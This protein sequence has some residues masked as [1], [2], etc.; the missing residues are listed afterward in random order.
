MSARSRGL[1]RCPAPRRVDARSIYSFAPFPTCRRCVKALTIRS[2]EPPQLPRTE[3]HV[4]DLLAESPR[5]VRA[6]VSLTGVN[7]I[8]T[9]DLGP[10]CRGSQQLAHSN[11]RTPTPTV[12][13]RVAP[14]AFL[15]G[16]LLVRRFSQ[17]RPR[18]P[19]KSLTNEALQMSLRAGL[20]FQ[21]E[22]TIFRELFGRGYSK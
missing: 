17:R 8:L 2:Y 19:K 16:A 12:T 22:R 5:H 10:L 7:A 9:Y 20:L 6:S 13:Q 4:S 15:L 21:T 14:L 18:A 11:Y 1:R 3:T